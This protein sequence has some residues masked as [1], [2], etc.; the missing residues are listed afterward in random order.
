M[1][2]T[3]N[4]GW[5]TPAP[6]DFVT[7]LPADFEVFADAVDADL[8]GLLGGTTGQVLTKVSGTDHDFAFADA[9]DPNAIQNAIIDA[10]GDLI[11]GTANDTPAILSIGTAAQV[12]AVNSGAT[13]PEW[14]TPASPSK[15]YTLLNS[16]NTGLS[17]GISTKT[18]SSLTGYDDYHIIVDQVSSSSSGAFMNF[19]FN[20]DTGSNYT[21]NGFAANSA[22][23]YS[24]GILGPM[25]RLN[26]TAY[27]LVGMS[28]NAGSQCFGG[29]HIFGAN[30]TNPK[31]LISAAGADV[32]GGTGANHY[33][34]LGYYSGTSAVTS[35]TFFCDAGNFDLGNVYIYGSA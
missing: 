30:S 9:D 23:T 26:Q 33:S 13:A 14:V 20:G 7:D 16:G 28:N 34:V 2:T 17:G 10:A 19:R 1:A 35:I 15:S 24:A 22:S 32:S 6:T 21:Q 18:W 4:Y 29:L 31:M 12:L 8:A 25:N 27:R 11:Y 5:V 3:P